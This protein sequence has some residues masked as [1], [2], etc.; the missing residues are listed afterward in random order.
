MAGPGPLFRDS[1]SGKD[2]HSVTSYEVPLVGQK[3]TIVIYEV[4]VCVQ[5]RVCTV[6]QT[7]NLMF[8]TLIVNSVTRS[9]SL[10]E[11]IQQPFVSILVYSEMFE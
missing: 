3:E 11:R 6:V 2:T 8:A 9:S 5:A 4:C 10:T 7:I 1:W